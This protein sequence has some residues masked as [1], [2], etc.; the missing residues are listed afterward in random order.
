[1]DFDVSLAEIEKI[2]E[3]AINGSDEDKISAA[4]IMCGASLG[5]GWNVQVLF[6]A[7]QFY[8]RLLFLVFSLFNVSSVPLILSII[9]SLSL[10]AGAYPSFYHKIAF[11][12]RSSQLLWG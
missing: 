12:Y 6:L 11:A 7:F 5:R 8:Q 3:I 10:F 9:C 1:M 4:T 2:Y